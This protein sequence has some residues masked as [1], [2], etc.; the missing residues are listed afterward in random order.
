MKKILGITVLIIVLMTSCSSLESDA[1][2][3]AKLKCEV[4]NQTDPSPNKIF[5]MQN[6]ISQME[7]E[8]KSKYKDRYQDF[9]KTYQEAFKNC[10]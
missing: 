1:K 3:L 8:F 2:K 7:K 6:K 10:E 9:E 5:K 4:L